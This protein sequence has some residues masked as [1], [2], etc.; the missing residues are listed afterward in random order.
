MK[1]FRLLSRIFVA[2]IFVIYGSAKV[3]GIQNF[4]PELQG[5]KPYNVDGDTS[6]FNPWPTLCDWVFQYPENNLYH[7]QFLRMFQAIS[8]EHHEATLRLVLQKAKF[9]S[10][11][12]RTCK[13]GGPL[14]GILLTCLNCLRLRSQSLPPRAF[15]RQFLESHDAWKD[16]QGALEA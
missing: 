2:L 14:R 7:V 13:A 4:A 9:V 11:A 10:R 1:I 6:V 3:L 5:E 15:L 8:L 16:F 12:V